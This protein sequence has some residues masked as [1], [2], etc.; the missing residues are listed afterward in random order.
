MY[1]I[2]H[3]NT[4]HAQDINVC[5]ICCCLLVVRTDVSVSLNGY[6]FKNLDNNFENISGICLYCDWRWLLGVSRDW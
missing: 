3:K 5:L 6:R 2:V 1:H 4:A